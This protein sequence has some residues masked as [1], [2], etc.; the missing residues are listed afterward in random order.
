MAGPLKRTPE[1]RLAADPARH[2]WV[3]ASAGTGKTHVLTDRMLRLMLRGSAPDRI[4]ALTFTRAAA[5][6]MQNRIVRRLGEWLGHDEARLAAELEAL[7]VAPTPAHLKRARGLFARALDVPGGLKVQTLHAFAQGLLAAF[8]L[9]AGLPPGFTALDERDARQL[10]RRALA[11]AISEAQVGGEEGFLADLAELAVLKGESGL[12][13]AID[14]LIGHS[15][16]IL[17]FRDAGGLAVAVR[18]WLGVREGEKPGERLAEMLAPGAFDDGR[19]ADF[20][21]ALEQWGWK[22]AQAQAAAAREWLAL[23]A[24]GRFARVEDLRNLLFDSRQNVRSFRQGEKAVPGIQAMAEDL[25]ADVELLLDF[26]RRVLTADLAARVLRAGHRV[27]HRYQALKRAAVAIDYDDMIALTVGLL[28]P[29]GM[30]GYVGW[31][32]DSRFDHVLVDEAQ[33]TNGRQWAI[34]GRL[35]EDFFAADPERRRSLF[36]VGDHKQAIY[37]FQGTDPQVFEGWRRKMAPQAEASGQALEVVDLALSFRSGPAVLGVVNAFLRTVGYEALGMAAEPPPHRP[38]RTQAPGEVV[39]WPVVRLDEEGEGEGDDEEDGSE[40]AD[41]EMARRLAAQV[42]DW[43][44]PGHPERLWLAA[45]NQ[46]AR[47]EHI[48][49]LLRK[50]SWLMA[51]L[52]AEL[53]ERR[54][55]VAGVDRLLLTEPLAVLD[56]LALI[57]FAVQPED[58]LNLACLLVSPFLGWGHEEVRALGSGGPNLWASLGRAGGERAAEA[59]SWLGAALALADRVGPYA[60]LDTLLS[61][62]LEGRR[63]LV[64]RLGPQ[65]NDPIDELLQQALAYEQRNPPALAAF[66]AWVEAEGSDVKR[67]SEAAAGQVR[68][69]TIHG[70]KGLEAPVVVLADSAHQRRDRRDDHL[71]VEI[72]GAGELPVFHPRQAEMPAKLRALKE[73]RRAVDAQEDLRLLYVGLTRAADHLYIGG[74]VGASGARKLGTENDKSWHGLLTP[75]LAAMPGVETLATG[76][77]ETLRLRGG[78]WTAPG[79][80][81]VE[82]HPREARHAP[83]EVVT[84]IAPPPGRPARPLTP[85]AMPEAPPE[86]PAAEAMRAAAMRGALIHK[87]FERLPAVPPPERRAQALGWLAAQQAGEAAEAILAEVLAVMDNPAHAALFGPEALA[88]AP[89]AG[90]IG[91]QAVAGIVDRLLVTEDRVLVVDF[92]TGLRVPESPAGAPVPHR[93]QMAAYAEV[94]KRA[95]PGRRVEAALLYTAAPKFLLLG[96]KDM[97]GLLPLD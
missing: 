46:W 13:Q 43:L 36:V 16:S 15:L 33:D 92:K 67:D 28:G 3:A 35:V 22:K 90:L 88:E 72:A 34:I 75:V 56:L 97:A 48:L 79:P 42:A 84:S 7:G 2:V 55:P 64:A 60:F 24:E 47:P 81:I 70:S 74:A 91:A 69:M 26:D 93:R 32:L 87:L 31:K 71:P 89:V 38:N 25:A 14:T 21:A 63:R 50:R 78:V 85:S 51:A 65:A 1:Q 17:A 49:I 27:V 6:E 30:P 58:D 82:L 53:H 96:E 37:G 94:L 23:G 8:P 11:E 77:G 61:G 39:L 86:G 66:L 29:E 41:R 52:V 40:A 95:F 44:K 12:M 45:R 57:R 5:A 19:L 62:P 54:V 80:D 10:K 76:W 59:R 68:L 20:A 4:L 9:E 18:D 83:S 73:A